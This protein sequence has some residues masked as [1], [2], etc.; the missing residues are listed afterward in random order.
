MKK[1]DKE[2]ED[3]SLQPLHGES[4]SVSAASIACTAPAATR[5]AKAKDAALPP[6]WHLHRQAHQRRLG[7]AAQRGQPGPRRRALP[8]R[9]SGVP[10]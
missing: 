7:P 2:V 1:K 10:A 6:P 4:V 5:R 8:R 3:E 9:A